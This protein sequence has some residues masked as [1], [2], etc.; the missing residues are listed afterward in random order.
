M[1]QKASLKL[2][3]GQGFCRRCLGQIATGSRAQLHEYGI[4]ITGRR[5]DALSHWLTR[6]S[7]L[8]ARVRM[9]KSE[10]QCWNGSFGAQRSLVALVASVST[11]GSSSGS[12]FAC[13]AA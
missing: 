4:R 6:W 12:A 9:K 13:R 5:T 3:A 1:T 7:H 11:R 10:R 2:N 8:P